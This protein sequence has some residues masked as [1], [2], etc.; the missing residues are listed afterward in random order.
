M[1]RLQLC[2][3]GVSNKK[4]AQ[5]MF[6]FFTLQLE[7]IKKDMIKKSETLEYLEQEVRLVVFNPNV[8]FNY[9]I[10]SLKVYIGKFA[11]LLPR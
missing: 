9:G 10:F 7:A 5:R 1:N 11:S 4:M 3:H 8:I 2:T 6:M